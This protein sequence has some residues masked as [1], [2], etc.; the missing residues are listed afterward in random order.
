MIN[1]YEDGIVGVYGTCEEEW[2]AEIDLA[3]D[4]TIVIRRRFGDVIVDTFTTGYCID[5]DWF[6]EPQS[7]F[8][9]EC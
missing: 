1:E 8:R 3:E 5:E 7:W 6:V 9:G 4:T 2:M